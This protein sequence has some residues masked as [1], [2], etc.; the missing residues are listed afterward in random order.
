M[1]FLKKLNI[2]FSK[3][4]PHMPAPPS[5]EDAINFKTSLTIG[6]AGPTSISPAWPPL[7]QVARRGYEGAR[8]GKVDGVARSGPLTGKICAAGPHDFLAVAAP[9]P[10]YRT[11]TANSIPHHNRPLLISP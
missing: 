4:D 2:D 8:R 10:L 5:S 3:R 9:F 7:A 11:P 1:A 6:Q